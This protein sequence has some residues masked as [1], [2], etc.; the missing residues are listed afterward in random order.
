M[1]LLA[2]LIVDNLGGVLEATG[3]GQEFVGTLTI[4]CTGLFLCLATYSLAILFC[5]RLF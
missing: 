3:L 1:A 4:T 5:L 2:E